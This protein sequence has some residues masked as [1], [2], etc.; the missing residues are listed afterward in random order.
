MTGVDGG[1]ISAEVE[2]GGAVS[3]HQ[4][5]NLPGADADLP[6][7]GATDAAWIDFACE[8]GID[9]LAVSFVRRPS[10]LEQGPRSAPASAAPTS[11]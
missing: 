6:E 10:D 7:S 8:H 11:R 5:V 3:S 4:G 2:A 1:E 9:L